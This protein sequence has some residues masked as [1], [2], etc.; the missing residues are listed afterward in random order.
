MIERN[1]GEEQISP[2]EFERHQWK[3]EEFDKQADHAIRIKELELESERIAAK[4]TA[5]FKIP[6]YLIKLPVMVVMGVGAAV[7]LARGKELSENFW[8]FLK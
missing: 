4:I 1:R 7:S 6:L 8:R 5:W 3:I 2:A